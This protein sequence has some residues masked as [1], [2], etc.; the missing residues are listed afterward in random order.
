M[1]KAAQIAA[2]TAEVM[3]EAAPMAEATVPVVNAGTLDWRKVALAAGGV[4]IVGVGTYFCI[5]AMKKR[6]MKKIVV[7]ESADK[8]VVDPS[9]EDTAE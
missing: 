1:V 7:I 8:P 4:V 6:N 5:K 2:E 9:L 3:A